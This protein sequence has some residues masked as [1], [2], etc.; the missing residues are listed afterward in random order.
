MQSYLEHIQV[1][2]LSN[3]FCLQA[4][5]RAVE[6]ALELQARRAGEAPATR[7][8]PADFLHP[9]TAGPGSESDE[10]EASPSDAKARTVAGMVPGMAL[11][12]EEMG[13]CSS[14]NQASG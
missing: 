14:A 5:S 6:E 4:F 11:L 10:P 12:P 1:A 9:P 3:A 2:V 7:H 8:C 13:T